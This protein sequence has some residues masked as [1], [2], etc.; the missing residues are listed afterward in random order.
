MQRTPSPQAATRLATLFM[1]LSGAAGVVYQVVWVRL[2]S[3]SI[4]ATSVSIA[5]VVA[6]FFAGLAGGSYLAGRLPPR[7][8]GSIGTYVAVELA[9]ALFA[10]A[11]LPLL[12]ELD[13][14]VLELGLPLEGL[15]GRALLVTALLALPCLAIGATYPLMVALVA[16]DGVGLSRL[17]AAN[18][19]GAVAGAVAAG[20]VLIPELGLDGAVYGAALLNLAVAAAG[21]RWRCL[22]SRGGVPAS[23]PAP[24]GPPPVAVALVLFLSGAV[25]LASQVVWSKYLSIYLHTTIYGFS[26]I[27]ALFLVG[28]AAGAWGVKWALSRGLCKG[29]GGTLAGLL[30]ALAATLLLSRTGLEWLPGWHQAWIDPHL[31][32]AARELFRYLLVWGVLLPPTLVMGGLFTCAIHLYC[33][34][35]GSLAR[36][37]EAYAVNTVGGIAGSLAAGLW[38]I[39][40]W[41]SDAVLVAAVAVALGAALLQAGAVGTRRARGALVAAAVGVALLVPLAPALDYSRM[42]AVS[43]YYFDPTLKVEQA[44]RFAFLREGRGAVVSL[45]TFDGRRFRLQNNSLPE[46]AVEVPDPFSWLTETLLG[47]G[48]W[49]LREA[50]RDL[51]VVGLGGGNTVAAAALAPFRS[52]EV[53]ELEPAVVEAVER[54]YPGGLAA[55]RDPRVTLVV[56][57][58]RH[59]LLRAGRRF[60]AIVTQPSHPWLAGAGNLFTRDYFELVA[61]RLTERGVALQW[62]NIVHMDA[63]TLRAI[64]RAHFEVFPHGMV[65][66]VPYESSLVLVGARQ[67]LSFDHRRLERRLGP[68]GIAAVLGRWGVASPFDLYRHF[69]LTRE[70]ALALAGDV[71]ANRDTRLIPEI[72]LARL[73]GPPRGEE[74]PLALLGR[75]MS[76]ELETVV[77]GAPAGWWQAFLAEQARRGLGWP[78]RP[79]ATEGAP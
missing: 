47:V 30:V 23:T 64:V 68:D 8:L 78:M 51:F 29:S 37:G 56:G 13:R 67:P 63:T 75:H 45:I 41:G 38:A 5:L 52:I 79:A 31:S 50:P 3:L 59:R 35:R 7:R 62:L 20:F 34:A 32:G 2:L 15:W 14:L 61:R 9:I 16:R 42:V 19:A 4:G 27:L 70:E 44:P 76:G 18:T 22:F 60:D 28:V 53:V 21:W 77:R 40:R 26:A 74:D 48:P 57:D 10:V 24:V 11:L 33:G 25:A 65:L 72:R 58:A 43:R 12:L 46:A 66:A 17:Y 71:A 39:P 1:L 54:L 6:I 73:D 49:L 55:L 69:A 36:A